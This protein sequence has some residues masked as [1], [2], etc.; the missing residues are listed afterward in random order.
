MKKNKQKTIETVAIPDF[1][2]VD[3]MRNVRNKISHEIE[4]MSVEQVL[5]YFEKRKKK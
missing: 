1:H 4:N 2:A 5:E 3:F